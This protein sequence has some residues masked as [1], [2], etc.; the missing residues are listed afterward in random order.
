MLLI[1][2]RMLQMCFQSARK[3]ENQQPW[4]TLNGNRSSNRMAIQPV[5]SPARAT[6]NTYFWMRARMH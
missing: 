4:I 6:L 1:I 3:K 5:Q 2:N